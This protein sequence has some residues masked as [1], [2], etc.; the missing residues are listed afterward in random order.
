MTSNRPSRAA[1][2]TDAAMSELE[3]C[4]GGQ[5]CP[6]TLEALLGRVAP[7]EEALPLPA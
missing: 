2:T 4:R 5:F 7:V 1:M 6:T 3:R